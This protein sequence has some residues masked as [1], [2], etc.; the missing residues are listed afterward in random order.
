MSKHVMVIHF[1]TEVVVEE[2]KNDGLSFLNTFITLTYT[3]LHNTYP[4][5]EPSHPSRDFVGHV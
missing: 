2:E 1:I 4:S 3:T 5:H